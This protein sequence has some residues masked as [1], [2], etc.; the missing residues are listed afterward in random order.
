MEGLRSAVPV[1]REPQMLCFI[2]RVYSQYSIKQAACKAGKTGF[3]QIGSTAGTDEAG[4]H[5]Q[6]PDNRAGREDK[7]DDMDGLVN[8]CHWHS[9]VSG[10]EAEKMIWLREGLQQQWGNI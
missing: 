3:F 8:R 4:G 7:V 10:G 6:K 2:K 5:T 9:C 1:Y